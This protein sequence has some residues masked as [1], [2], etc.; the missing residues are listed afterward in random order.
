M[1]ESSVALAVPYQVL[2]KPPKADTDQTGELKMTW[3]GMEKKKRFQTK[4][5][6]PLLCF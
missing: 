1:A 2:D 6:N 4:T 5:Q 3:W